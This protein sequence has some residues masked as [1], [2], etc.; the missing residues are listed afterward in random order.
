MAQCPNCERHLSRFHRSRLQKL[1]YAE[2]LRCGKCGFVS[3]RLHLFL[4][5]AV[6]SHVSAYT[7]CVRCGTPHVV[8]AKKRDR[9][10]SLSNGLWSR[11]HQILGAP[12]YRCIGCRLQY[13]DWRP[14]RSQERRDTGHVTPASE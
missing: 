7:R 5:V 8:R 2:I 9:M 1:I 11:V 3:R 10:E 14:S 12:I 13:Y 6:M 4:R